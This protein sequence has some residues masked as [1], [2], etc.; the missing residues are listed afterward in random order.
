MAG[1]WTLY[2]RQWTLY[3]RRWGLYIPAVTP[4]DDQHQP[5][6]F[7]PETIYLDEKGRPVPKGYKRKQRAP[8]PVD[9]RAPEPVAV[10]AKAPEIDVAPLV[11]KTM[12]DLASLVS[13]DMRAAIA[14]MKYDD[15]LALILL[16]AT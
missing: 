4:V 1:L 14:R 10:A 8:E 15:D 7:I 16:M 5:G 12:A 6:G 11:A 13:R 2:G 9:A 3:G